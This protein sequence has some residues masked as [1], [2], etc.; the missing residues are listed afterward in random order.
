MCVAC[1]C[2]C[3]CVR[4]RACACLR[5]LVQLCVLAVIQSQLP[6]LLLGWAVA[7]GWV[8]SSIASVILAMTPVFTQLLQMLLPRIQARLLNA[9]WFYK[10]HRLIPRLKARR[11]KGQMLKPRQET[12]LERDRVF[13][14]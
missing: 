3:V 12:R 11:S 6:V 10:G 2:V 8:E 14:S 5:V 13:S 7:P 4:A 1:V 9:V